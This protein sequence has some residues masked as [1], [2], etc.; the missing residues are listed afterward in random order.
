MRSL[1]PALLA[2]LLLPACALD[3][4]PATDSTE[5]ASEH[6]GGHGGHCEPEAIMQVG[7]FDGSGVIDP[8]DIEM[9]SAYVEAGDYAAF[10][11]MNADGALDGRDVSTVAARMGEA[12]TPR[13]AQMAALWAT[14]EPYRDVREAL[15]AGYEPF[16]PD[17]AGHGIHFANFGLINSWPGR[18][19]QAGAPEGLNYTASGEL[20]AAFYYAPGAFDLHEIYPDNYPADTYYKLLSVPPSFDGVMAHE[21]HNHI[22]A[23]FG[24]ATSP[25]PGFDQCVPKATCLDQYGAN[26][27]AD[28]FHMLHVWLFEYNEC[29]AFAGIDTDVSP[30]APEEPGHMAC[31]LDDIVPIVIP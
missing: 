4:D 7:D 27:W 18:G 26:L 1:S 28:K 31:T 15:A 14:T 22:G 2:F 8:A 24:G 13:D 16:T 25:V 21:W 10:F 20:V 29:G 19:F 30:S 3:G 17:L 6:H 5:L 11:D 12:G 9:I 23:C